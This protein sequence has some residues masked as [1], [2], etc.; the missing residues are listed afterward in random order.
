MK[1]LEALEVRGMTSL[2]EKEMNETDGGVLGTA[3]AI[4]M[5]AYRLYRIPPVRKAVNA[6]AK[7]AFKGAAAYL[8]YKATTGW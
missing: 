2:S 7:A 8:G 6:T 3:I 1:N 5:G 4:G